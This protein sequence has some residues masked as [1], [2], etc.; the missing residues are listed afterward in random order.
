MAL[1]TNTLNVALWVIVYV[2]LI[3]LALWMIFAF[4][5]YKVYQKVFTFIK[6]LGGYIL[7][8]LLKLADLI[9]TNP[10]LCLTFVIA[11]STIAG[12]SYFVT[13]GYPSWAIGNNWG[14]F[15]TIMCILLGIASS[16]GLFVIFSRK[17]KGGGF[18]G[19]PMPPPGSP[20][21]ARAQ[22]VGGRMKKFLWYAI[23]AALGIALFLGLLYGFTYLQG[24]TAGTFFNIAMVLVGIGI[25]FGIYSLVSQNTTVRHWLNNNIIFSALYHLIF[26]IPCSFWWLVKYM[27]KEFYTTPHF[28]YILLGLEL[29]FISGFFLIPIITEK[30]YHFSY[31]KV[32][33]KAILQQEIN[34]LIQSK[35]YYTTLN[36]NEKGGPGGIEWDK[37]ITQ[38]LNNKPEELK[39][40]VSNLGFL[41]EKAAGSQAEWTIDKVIKYIKNELPSIINIRNYIS[42]TEYNIKQK[43]TELDNI[44]S[45]LTGVTLLKRPIP[46]DIE[47][48]IGTYQNLVNKNSTSFNYNYAISCWVFIHNYGTN[49]SSAYVVDT[50]LLNYGNRPAITWNG[51]I[52]TLKIK[53]RDVNN[54]VLTVFKTNKIPLQKWVNIVIN[55]NGGTLDVFIDNKLVASERNIIPYMAYD[56][57]VVGANNGI[58]GGIC[59]VTYYDNVL[60]KNQIDIYYNLLKDKNPPIV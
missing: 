1:G 28:V 21:K 37:I 27:Y 14:T 22:W 39:K 45:T 56:K 55:Y 53:M 43:Q 31:G 23:I 30:I 59:N 42:D 9:K 3:I 54:N 33:K 52:N 25:I 51:K 34:T 13:S 60:T 58:S 49:L 36:S 29:L 20:F 19:P 38:N 26:V 5:Y 40:Y 4:F 48:T 57:I 12:L 16:I 32:N 47:K 7:A 2:P 35:D 24:S 15:L 11:I 8:G 10:V 41:D 44:S 46:M 50:P 18:G 6:W 17:I